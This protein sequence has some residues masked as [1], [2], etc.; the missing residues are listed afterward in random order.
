MTDVVVMGSK[1]GKTLGWKKKKKS[2]WK[3][4]LSFAALGAELALLALCVPADNYRVPTG[5]CIPCAQS[6]NW[7]TRNELMNTYSDKR[8]ASVPECPHYPANEI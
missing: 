4:V 3:K 1:D 8:R 5:S 2:K 6:H 7:L